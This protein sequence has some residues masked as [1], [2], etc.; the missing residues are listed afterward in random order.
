L[1]L[2]LQDILNNLLPNSQTLL[3]DIFLY[4]IFFISLIV[5]FMQSD[6]Q[7]LPTL[8]MA[9]TVL[10]TLLSKLSVTAREPFHPAE[11]AMLFINLAM[12]IFPALV[13]PMTKAKKSRAPAIFVAVLAFVYTFLFWFINQR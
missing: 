7:L 12:F 5:V 4:P 6:K 9:S 10:L 1:D 13:A 2:S 11:I 8:L 3:Y